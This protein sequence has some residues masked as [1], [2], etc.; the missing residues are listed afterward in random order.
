MRT[1]MKFL[2]P[3]LG[4]AALL[5]GCGSS[6]NSSS[7]SS[8]SASTPAA[9][10]AGGE[11]SAEV[12]KTAASSKLGRTILV[13][14]HGMTLYS[15]SGEQNGKFICTNSACLQT[16]HPLAAQAGTT[17]KG[18]VGA[19]GTVKRPDGSQQVTYKG[20]PLYTF[21]LDH[22]AGSVGGQGFKDVG[23]WSAVTAAASGATTS[24]PATTSTQK[25]ETSRGGYGG[26]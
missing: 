24:T 25:T 12:V 4:A 11:S 26:Y 3:T 20:M 14:A 21:A 2:I 18:T 1:P 9:S 23:T 17:A 10:S 8:A 6:S 16:W 22:A 7:G 13:D 15:L 5:A 19:L